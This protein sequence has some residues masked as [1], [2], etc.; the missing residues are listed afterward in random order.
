MRRRRRFAME[1]V[2]AVLSP[3]SAFWRLQPVFH[4]GDVGHWFVAPHVV[5]TDPPPTPF[6]AVRGDADAAAFETLDAAE[7]LASPSP[8]LAAVVALLGAHY[9]RN[10]DNV[11]VPTAASVRAHFQGHAAPSYWTLR[12]TTAAVTATATPAIRTRELESC[13]SSRPVLAHFGD[14]GVTMP[15]YYVDYLC[16]AT[17]ARGRGVA[18]RTIQT[19][20]Y[21]RRQ[22]APSVRVSVFKREGELTS[23]VPLM[24]YNTSCFP[25][26]A[27]RDV[28]AE[29][30]AMTIPSTIAVVATRDEMS[31]AYA[32]AVAEMVARK[33]V[34]LVSEC[35][36][37]WALAEAGVLTL[38]ADRRGAA[39]RGLFFFRRSALFL[40]KDREVVDCFA[41]V[42]CSGGGVSADDFARAFD[43]AVATVLQRL[44]RAATLSYVSLEAI[45]DSADLAAAS[46][47]IRRAGPP[48]IVSPTAYFLYNYIHPS[49][50][51]R[52]CFVVM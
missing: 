32:F 40:A 34:C 25:A 2:R 1:F 29:I 27:W 50:S 35:D 19:H 31:D 20:E 16:V 6:L 41:S 14:I 11:F 26:T 8:R 17:A 45:G 13:I 3:P 10:G 21:L 15:V 51:A 12:W 22:L 42:R 46:A 4:Y 44:P 49:V 43:A 28:T 18:P 38:V 24:S 33:K 5:H 39:I 36:N 23:I 30:R 37:W 47:T 7:L 9:L 52:D 48:V